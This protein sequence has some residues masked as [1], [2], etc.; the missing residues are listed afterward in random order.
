MVTSKNY[1]KNAWVSK[2]R[3]EL[4][5]NI[6]DIVD[7]IILKGEDNL[8][9]IFSRDVDGM[10]II[11]LDVIVAAHDPIRQKV[12]IHNY[13]KETSL[14]VYEVPKEHNYIVGIQGNLFPV[15]EFNKGELTGIKWYSDQ[16]K[17]DLIIDVSVTYNRDILGFVTDRTTVRTWINEDG[18][19]NPDT[20]VKIKEYT[21]KEAIAEGVRRRTNIF[22]GFQQPTIGL[23]IQ[24]A[25]M[26]AMTA[27]EEGSIFM[28]GISDE[29]HSFI[30]TPKLNQF[31][32]ALN[33]APEAWLDADIGGGTTIRH[34]LL[35]EIDT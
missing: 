28:D 11:P 4:N 7:S 16:A 6:T 27:V 14:N 9:V 1:V 3:D 35:N 18:S 29:I 30:H 5:A 23:M 22:D 24:F 17:T 13:I 12:K 2:L 19:S 32:D 33:A 34:Y 20:K 10:E 26:D 15:R 25:G 21:A 8:K 31:P